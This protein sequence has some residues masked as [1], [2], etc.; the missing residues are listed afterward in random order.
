VRALVT[1][2]AGFVGSHLAD[3][4]LTRGDHVLGVDSFTPYYARARKEANLGAARRHEHFTFVRAD[5]TDADLDAVL[6]GIDVVFHQAAQPCVRL[7]WAEGFADYVAHNV[8]ATQRLLEAVKRTGTRRVVY[9]SSSSVY[10][11]QPRYPTTEDDLPQPYS[12]YG[13]TKLA[14][15]HLCALY[16]ENWG[17]STV[18]LRYFTVYGPRQRPDMSI[19]RLCDAALFHKPFPKYGD[20]EQVREFTFV[21]DIVRANLLAADADVEPGTVCNLAG[22]GEITLN[23]LIG[24]VGEVAGRAVKVDEQPAEPGDARRNGG[25]VERAHRLLGW[26]PQ[27]ALRDGVAAQY[28]WHKSLRD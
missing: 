27:V 5:L 10:G 20:G 28:A 6:D 8:L 3:A 14:A 7:S 22:G 16:A 25:A 13:V 1:G 12:P 21:D 15:E 23:E 11:N 26:E 24:L 18:A 2:V 17:C 4:L 9:A 19:Y